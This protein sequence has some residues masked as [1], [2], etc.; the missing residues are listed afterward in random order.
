LEHPLQVL[1]RHAFFLN[2]EKSKY[3][4]GGYYSARFCRVVI[5][6]GGAHLSPIIIDE[7]HLSTLPEHMP[8][9]CESMCRG[10]RYACKDGVFELSYSGGY[11]DVPRLYL[12]KRY[13]VLKLANLRYLM[14]M[15][16]L[17][18]ALVN[19]YTQTHDDVMSNVASARGRTV[20]I[21]PHPSSTADITYD[22][23]FEEVKM[24]LIIAMYC[25]L[26]Q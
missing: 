3:V 23:L 4:S 19:K 24:P 22:R 13:I 17:V 1:L 20:F 12:D 21:H 11:L 18:Q 26:I 10:E 15:L 14:N 9:L 5:E 6:F 25:T 8:K 16:Y 2:S 7:Q